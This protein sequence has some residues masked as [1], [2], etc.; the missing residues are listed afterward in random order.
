MNKFLGNV[1]I[2]LALAMCALCAYQ[3]YR[4]TRQ[5]EEVHKLNDSIYEKTLA[6]RGNTNSI[7]LMDGKI[8]QL[9]ARVGELKGTVKTNEATL[10][11]Q[12][13]EIAKLEF[14]NV[15]LTNQL[16]EYKQALETLQNRLKEAYDGVE[17]Q[18]QVLKD[19]AA[20]RD[21]YINKLNDS[22]R[23]R[24]EIVAKYNELVKVAEKLQEELT[25]PAQ[26][27]QSQPQR[28]NSR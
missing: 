27:K 25:K 13:R 3:W 19:V 10:L 7:H 8:A 28:S 16:A 22:T 24:N 5:R 17:K 23:E 26:P 2:V 14:S 6:I 21:E 4:E 9:D 15:G 11:E 1:L 20:Q 18:N 12:K